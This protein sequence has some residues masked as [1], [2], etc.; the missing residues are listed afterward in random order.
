MDPLNDRFLSLLDINSSKALR[1]LL[2]KYNNGWRQHDSVLGGLSAIEEPWEYDSFFSFDVYDPLIEGNQITREDYLK[3]AGARVLVSGC[4]ETE[5]ELVS[6]N[7]YEHNKQYMWWASL[8]S[9]TVN[10]GAGGVSIY[11]IVDRIFRYV[12]RHD[13]PKIISLLLPP[14]YTRVRIALDGTTLKASGTPNEDGRTLAIT[15]IVT[16]EN[17]VSFS[18]RPHVIEEILPPV[19]Y[20][21]YNLNQLRYL[22]SYCKAAGIALIYTTWDELSESI[23]MVANEHV[24]SKGR[25]AA[26][27][28]FFPS[29]VS[30]WVAQRKSVQEGVDFPYVDCHQAL[31]DSTEGFFAYGENEHM[32]AHRQAHIGEEFIRQLAMRDIYL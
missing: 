5:G 14:L 23:F 7:G 30:D 13:A 20:I 1:D 26:F 18:K 21:Y 2:A 11:G 32:G 8:G 6:S 15:D 4:S 9:D 29:N 22:E 10:L 28:S 16:N 27:S 3:N 19:S 24:T 25:P 12:E 17:I 31:R